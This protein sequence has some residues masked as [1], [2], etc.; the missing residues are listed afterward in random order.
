MTEDISRAALLASDGWRPLSEYE[1]REYVYVRGF[2]F[3]LRHPG[4]GIA[5]RGRAP[6]TDVPAIK[7]EAGEVQAA[8]EKAA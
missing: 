2:G 4:V 8:V 5:R 7:T 1:G 3:D 6:E